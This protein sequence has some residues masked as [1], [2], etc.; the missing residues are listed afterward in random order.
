MPDEVLSALLRAYLTPSTPLGPSDAGQIKDVEVAAKLFDFHNKSFH[1]LLR[2]ELSVLIGRRGSGKTALL[3]SYKYR[4]YLDRHAKPAAVGTMS[5]F[6]SYDMVIDVLTYKQFDDMQKVVRGDQGQFRPIEA[7][8]DD[9]QT[10]VTDYFFAK[11]VDEEMT[12][13]RNTEPIK[14]LN[15]YLHQDQDDYKRKI[16][17]MVWGVSLLD[18]VKSFLHIHTGDHAKM[19]CEDALA[20]AATYLHDTKR[21]VLLIC[22]SMDEYNVGDRGFDRTLGALIRFI[23]QFNSRQD[24]V[25]IKLGLPA[26]IFPEVSRASANAL[27]DLGD[28]DQVTWTA[29]ELAQIAAHRFRLFLELYDV[30][31]FVRVADLDVDQRTD[32]RV[33]WNHFFPPTV[34]NRYAVEE[35]PLTYIFRHTQLLP[36]QFLMTLQKVITKSHVETG[37]YRRFDAQF[38]SEAVESTEPLIASEI[39]QAFGHVYPAAEALCKPIFANFPTVFSYDEL[40]DRWRKV[41]RAV[42][43]RHAPKVLPDFD[44]PEFGEML[45]RMGI[46]GVGHD[47]TDRYHEGHFGYDSIAPMN[48]GQGH[49]L[50]LHPIFSRHFNAAGNHK[51]KAVIPKGISRLRWGADGHE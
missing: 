8:V 3:N 32:V 12:E 13:G 31:E 36:R 51:A 26:E 42:A 48:I 22:D 27:K 9:W 6:R 50:C 18:R 2:R 30:D 38:V 23:S 19:N 4:P 21:R 10:F 15:H 34:K 7:I 25:R 43:R 33:F 41:G 45:V 24:R 17:E 1:T 39:L 40:E 20:L 28:V 37:S 49:A 16:R 11:L 35:E 5:D 47:E 44:M 29:G 46:V 14:R